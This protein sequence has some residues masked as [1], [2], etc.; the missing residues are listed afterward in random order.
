M[1]RIAVIGAGAWGTALATVARRAGRDVVIHAHEA[2]TAAAINTE[3][4][5]KVFLPGIALD[6]AIVATD[7]LAHAADSADAIVMVTP[8]QFLRATLTTLAPAPGTPMIICS[9]GIELDTGKLMNEVAEETMPGANLAVLS[10]P[11]FAAEVAR[12][13]PTAVTLACTNADTAARLATALGTP[14]FRPYTATDLV[15]AEVGGAIK[16]VIAIACGIV[17]GRAL[18]QNAR[19]AIIARGLAEIA[20]FA[21]ALDA[22]PRTL[23]GL[24]GLGDLT[25]TCT[26]TASRNYSLGEALGS[27]TPYADAIA[28]K[29]SVA[30]GATTAPA[31]LTRAAA[32]GV[33]MPICAAV[34]AILHDGAGV[35]ETITDILARPLR[36]EG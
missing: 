14:S 3:H 13:L 2:E 27:G 12:G 22:D 35:D 24:S 29:S 33:E 21:A 4:E 9:K 25:L 15:G 32:L 31:V 7:D 6:P 36:A 28:G 5:N 34:S 26:S 11:T 17:E 30:E 18:G 20:R 1:Q 19:A 16:N 10:G 23:M 8:A